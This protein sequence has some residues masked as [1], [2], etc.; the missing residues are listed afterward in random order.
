MM[1]CR[2]ALLVSVLVLLGIQVYA[3]ELYESG[4]SARALGMGN[5][6]TAVVN[7]RNT[8][9][10]NPAGLNRVE[11]YYYTIL[12]MAA[13]LNGEQALTTIQDVSNA[14][15]LSATLDALYDQKLWIGYNGN[16]AIYM[17]N[18][19]F[20]YFLDGSLDPFL[21]NPTFPTYNINYFN[22]L[23]YATGFSFDI[24]E[25]FAVG[26]TYRNINRTGGAIPVGVDTLQ[27]LS[28]DDLTNSV[29]QT[30]SANA[31]DF[32]VLWY[33]PTGIPSRLSFVYKNLGNTSFKATGTSTNAPNTIDAE[34]IVGWSMDIE[35][36]GVRIT[37]AI[38][39]KHIN[40]TDVQLGKKIHLG[41]EVDL[42]LITVRGGFNQGYY[43]YGIGMGLGPMDIEV[44]SYGVE[45]G[46]YPGQWED[47]RYMVQM[48]MELGFDVNLNFDD[49]GS[50]NRRKLKQRR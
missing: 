28:S 42:P 29:N 10:Y 41:V 15:D 7:D 17:K 46:A 23:G 26:F 31:L 39:Y 21:E 13:G 33:L 43:T 49:F 30:G 45:L 44:A 5:A 19:G 36:P 3:Q 11:G 24:M 22:D 25:T 16:T 14:A 37:P 18:F 6:F 8:M 27:S 9:F 32:G 40:R 12:D 50:V 2:R 1:I 48:T 20:V 35:V 4:K 38:D 47:R 34:M